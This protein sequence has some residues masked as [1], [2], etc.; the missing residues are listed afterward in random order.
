[1]IKAP[2]QLPSPTLPWFDPRTGKPTDA[3]YQYMRDLDDK[4]RKILELLNVEF[5]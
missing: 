4:V 3:Y 5:P 2:Q 1:M